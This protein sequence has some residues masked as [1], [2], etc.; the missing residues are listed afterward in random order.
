MP[1]PPVYGCSELKCALKKLGFIIDETRGKGGHAL[2]KHP[3]RTNGSKV[4]PFV[5]IKGDKEYFDPKF[6]SAII[7]EIMAFKFTK[8]E[9]TEAINSC[10]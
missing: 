9:V 8:R 3:T 6:R 1:K 5:T 10:R 7:R 4:R 2:A